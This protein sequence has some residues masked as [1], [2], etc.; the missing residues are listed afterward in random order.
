MP[1]TKLLADFDSLQSLDQQL[2]RVRQRF[3]HEVAS[4]L[5]CVNDLVRHVERYRGKMLRPT[6]VLLTASAVDHPRAFA[7]TSQPPEPGPAIEVLAAVME[8]VH[9]ATLVHDDVLDEAD[10]RRGGETLNALRG[11]EAAVMLGDYLISH[12]YRLCS[13]LDQQWIAQAVADTTNT[14][15]EGELLQLSNRCNW[16]L[17]QGVYIEMIRRKT[18]SLC[19]SC[20]RLAAVMSDA[21]PEVADAAYAYGEQ[22]GIAFQIVDDVLDLV[23]DEQTVGKSLGRDL[24]KGKLTL[25]LILQIENDGQAGRKA[26]HDRLNRATRSETAAIHEVRTCLMDSALDQARA[27]AA[28][29]VQKAIG[30]LSAFPENPATQALAQLAGKVLSRRS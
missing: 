2:E 24:Q 17:K 1:V 11:N 9:M 30:Q 4:D 6:L 25:P 19:G 8:M 7:L 20:C 13:S 29:H 15:C 3:D 23:G 10:L 21:R 16:G 22:I 18:A 26:W 27:I 14:V 28:E 12:A 5:D